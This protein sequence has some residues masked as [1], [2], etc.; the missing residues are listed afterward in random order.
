MN[1][2]SEV[3]I[4]DNVIAEAKAEYEELGTLTAYTF[5]A[6]NNVGVDAQLFLDG[7]DLAS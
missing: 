1:S 4:K 5:I 2:T 6:L 3:L 7:M